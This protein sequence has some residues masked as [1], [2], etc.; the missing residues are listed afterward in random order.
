MI[1]IVNRGFN[2][3]AVL[4]DGVEVATFEWRRNRERIGGRVV[5]LCGGVLND[6]ATGETIQLYHSWYADLVRDLKHRYGG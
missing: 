3:K 6:N 1:K 4:R 2:H 5:I